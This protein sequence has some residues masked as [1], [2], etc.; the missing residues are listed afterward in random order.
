MKKP[1]TLKPCP[2]CG[3]R[4][5]TFIEYRNIKMLDGSQGEKVFC[6]SCGGAT[7]IRTHEDAIKLW[8]ERK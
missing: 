6:L 3:G 2:F 8:N 1:E 5:L 4:K 7:G